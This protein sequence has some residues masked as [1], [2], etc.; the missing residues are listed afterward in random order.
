ML[1]MSNWRLSADMK[2]VLI[3]TDRVKVRYLLYGRPT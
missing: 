3:E 1:R 2:H